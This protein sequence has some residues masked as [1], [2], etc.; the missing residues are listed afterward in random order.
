MLGVLF[1]HH[2]NNVLIKSQCGQLHL[3]YFHRYI[4]VY[5]KT[6]PLNLY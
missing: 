6:I 4:N 1:E 3:N 5:N 2:T